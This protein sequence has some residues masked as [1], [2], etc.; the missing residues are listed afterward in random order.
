VSLRTLFAPLSSISRVSES[1][2]F[3]KPP[4]PFDTCPR[5]PPISL[6]AITARSQRSTV[7][8]PHQIEHKKKADLMGQHRQLEQPAWP[9]A[10]NQGES[11]ALIL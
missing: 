2:G 6:P 3:D 7:A 11:F 5:R 4:T 10:H 9:F 1:V 8:E